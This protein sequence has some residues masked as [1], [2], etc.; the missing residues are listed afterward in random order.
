MY[1]IELR[2]E[3]IMNN[4]VFDDKEQAIKYIKEY[5]EKEYENKIIATTEN[6]VMGKYDIYTLIKL[7]RWRD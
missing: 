2:F 4:Y 7:D 5:E 6:K 1:I 3:G